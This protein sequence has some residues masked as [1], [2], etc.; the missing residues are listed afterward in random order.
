MYEVVTIG[1]AT[2][3]IFW[4]SDDFEVCD[5]KLQLVWGE[6]KVASDIFFDIGGGSCNAAVALARLGIKTAFWGQVGQD[7]GGEA[8][9]QRLKAEGVSLQFLMVEDKARTST[10]ALL[11]SP[12]GEHAIVMYRGTNDDLVKQ[13]VPWAEV[14][15][16]KW[17]YLADVASQTEDLTFKIAQLAEEKDINLC[18][19]PGQHQLQLG[20]KGLR[21]V[22]KTAEIL[23]LNSYEAATLLKKKE[24]RIE[25]MLREFYQAGTGRV[26]ITKDVDGS[27]AY[28]GQEVIHCPAPQTRVIDT[29]GAGDAFSSAFLAAQLKGLSLA[30]GLRWG[31]TNAGAVI[32]QFGAQTG[33][34]KEIS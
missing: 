4:V 14:T 32:A 10:S 19:V 9:A 21:G 26:V 30:E 13:D 33:L 12:E 34:L 11:C 24:D 5:S 8:I 17:F 27:W 1:G 31:A 15:Q 29:T 3:D 18:F 25:E 2:R 6:K 22:L 23:I 28:D 20:I 16:T 7:S